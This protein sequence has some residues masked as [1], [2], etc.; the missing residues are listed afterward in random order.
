[1][2]RAL[3]RSGIRPD[4]VVGTS[5]GAIN[6]YCF[7][8]HPTEK[9][10]DRL[11]RLWCGVRRRDIFPVNAW[12]IL[13]GLAGRRDGVV[14]PRHLRAFLG[15]HVGTGALQDTYV[16]VHIVATDLA[17]GQPVVLSRGSALEALVASAALP[18]VF[19]PVVVDNRTLVDGGVTS[20]V[21]IREAEELGATETYVLP[22]VG[23]SEPWELPHGAVPV[24]LQAVSHLFGRAAAADLAEARGQVHVLPAPAGGAANPFDFRA[25]AQLV[26]QSYQAA[27]AALDSRTTAAQPV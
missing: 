9:G 11:Q 27:M 10:L 19:P 17:A 26:E 8:Q 4:L 1:M 23:P 18:G 24:L 7:A 3:T 20:D 12:H 13:S 2:L 25:T 15:R 16:P 6:A 5:A 22:S 21:P 14:S